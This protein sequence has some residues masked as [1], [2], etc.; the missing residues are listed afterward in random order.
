MNMYDLAV[1][2]ES[3]MEPE[4]DM[5]KNLVEKAQDETTIEF[6]QYLMDI[7]MVEEERLKLQM[8]KK[9]LIFM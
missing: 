2:N 5:S 1:K 3:E 6:Y 4:L 7:E 9:G 8:Q